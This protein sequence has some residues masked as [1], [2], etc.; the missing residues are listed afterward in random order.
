MIGKSRT[1]VA[2]GLFGVMSALGWQ[3]SLGALQLTQETFERIIASYVNNNLP[4]ENDR[5]LPAP[6]IGAAAK[7]SFLAMDDAA[8]AGAVKELGTAAKAFVMS[9]AYQTAFSAYLKQSRDAVDHGIAVKDVEG[10]MQAALK[11]GK[12]D[13][14]QKLSGEMMRGQLRKQVLNEL[15]NIG[16]M[17][18][19]QIQYTPE[20]IVG[21][22]GTISPMTP[23]E[24]AALAK[25]KPLMTE[26]AKL[27]PSDVEKARASYKA[28]LML[29]AGAASDADVAKAL[30]DEKKGEQQIR[31][32]RFAFKPS[33]KRKLQAFVELAKSVDFKAAT[34]PKGNRNVFTNPAYEKKDSFWKMLYRLG[35]GGTN[36]AVAVAQGWA[37][38][39]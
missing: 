23:A 36:A 32:N 5:Y 33:M 3:S 21:M 13:L 26:A 16:K 20:S 30:E 25:A 17:N 11:Q 10:E 24:K 7:K 15:A 2:L 34:A 27:A 8:R 14:A 19:S 9:P 12:Y 28:G 4:S 39:L 37:A 38:E 31:Y 18:Q 22:A 29:L 1:A 35:P 6:N